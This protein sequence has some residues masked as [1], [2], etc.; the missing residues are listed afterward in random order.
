MLL[1]DLQSVL[2]YQ[3]NI[4]I[5]VLQKFR[6]NSSWNFVLNDIFNFKVIW[7]AKKNIFLFSINQKYRLLRR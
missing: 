2:Y 7:E 3:N 6:I 1:N 5:I 4:F